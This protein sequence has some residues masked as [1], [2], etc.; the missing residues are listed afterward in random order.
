[1]FWR[2]Y[3]KQQLIFCSGIFFEK[4]PFPIV[5]HEKRKGPFSAVVHEKKKG[6]FSAGVPKQRKKPLIQP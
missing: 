5:V 6:P 3:N 2:G 1:M 4:A